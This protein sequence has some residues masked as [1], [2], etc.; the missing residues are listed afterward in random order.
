MERGGG[1]SKFKPV[2]IEADVCP[3]LFGVAWA[4]TS[5]CIEACIFL[6][7]VNVVKT[8]SIC[9]ATTVPMITASA[10]VELLGLTL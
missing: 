3:T 6:V 5:F 9:V 1:A 7:S 4:A 8:L 2:L 10:Y